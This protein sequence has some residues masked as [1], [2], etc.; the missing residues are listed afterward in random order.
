M[1]RI[2]I[3][4]ITALACSFLALSHAEAKKAD[5]SFLLTTQQLYNECKIALILADKGNIKQFMENDC[6][7]LIFFYFQGYGQGIFRMVSPPVPEDQE[8]QKFYEKTKRNADELS[9]EKC[10]RLKNKKAHEV[11]YELI[12][13]FISYTDENTRGHN[14]P[15]A[16]EYMEKPAII[17]LLYT[18]VNAEQHCF[19]GV[20][21]A[22]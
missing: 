15:Y 3:F 5:T 13:I 2:F 19:T 17:S 4:I 8:S 9:L 12:K 22:K 7:N 21:H 10:T 18:M 16:E 11:V 1:I 14:V 20:H 6:T